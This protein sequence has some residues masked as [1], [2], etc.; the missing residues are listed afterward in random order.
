MGVK[1]DLSEKSDPSP[2]ISLL[3]LETNEYKEVGHGVCS[4]PQ[5]FHGCRP[6]APIDTAASASAPETEK[7]SAGALASC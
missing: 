1:G 4:R 7:Q 3:V 5:Q 6:P 2:K